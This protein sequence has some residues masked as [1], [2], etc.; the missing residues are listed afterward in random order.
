MRIAVLLSLGVSWSREAA[1]RLCELGH[2]VHA[3]DFESEVTGNY[4][5]GRDDLHSEGIAKL[6]S[7]VAGIHLIP[8]SD[9][10]QL[11]YLRYAPRLRKICKDIKGDVLLSLWGGG[12]A[13]I[14]CASGIRPYAVF[15]GGGDILRVSG[16]QKMMSR[17]A[18]D[19]AAISFANGEYFGEKA[20]TFAP[21]ASI[22]SIYLGVDPKRFVPGTPS[23]SPVVIIC[24][25]GFAPVYNNGYL[26]E[27]LAHLPD[28]LPD[29][30]VVF[31]SAG[32]SFE[33]TRALADRILTP[34]MRARVRFL[35]GVTDEGMLENLR[36]AHI[37]TS[38]SRYDGTSISLLEALSCGLFPILSD[39][40]QN[41]EWI[42]PQVRN[43]MLVP[44]DQPATYARLLEE[45]IRD[46]DHRKNV[47][48]FN[49]RLILDRAD[50]RKTMA[51]VASLL[52]AAI[53]SRNNN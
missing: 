47:A 36:N 13:M 23:P 8:G 20:K 48:G 11:R 50:G 38:L 21:N 9:I 42:D 30:K 10:S 17:Y 32:E 24:T 25:R 33:R 34:A 52:E 22:E 44:L 40:P 18:L 6:R 4:L 39:I 35:N 49:R 29:F 27:A 26:I 12:F 46:A 1:L 43:G 14:S 28:S 7:S 31:T 45:A 37:Y 5:R 16:I 2:E 19:R 51:R 53:G 3:I 41:S 15:L